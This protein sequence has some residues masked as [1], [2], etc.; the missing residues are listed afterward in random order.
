MT[1]LRCT[2]NEVIKTKTPCSG[3]FCGN[4]SYN[5]PTLFRFIRETTSLTQHMLPTSSVTVPNN[6]RIRHANGASYLPDET[7]PLR[8]WFRTASW[9]HILNLSCVWGLFC[10]GARPVQSEE[11]LQYH[12]SSLFVKQCTSTILYCWRLGD[13]FPFISY[14]L[15]MQVKYAGYLRFCRP[16]PG[17]AC[18]IAVL[19]NCVLVAHFS[20]E[21]RRRR[22][23]EG[24]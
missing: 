3:R 7:R 17:V 2:F 24:N 13:V 22:K 15:L 9:P 8:D 11:L 6:K 19:T 14:L 16:M 12:H 20:S 21:R 4:P 10:L 5:K 1:A 23:G 18:A